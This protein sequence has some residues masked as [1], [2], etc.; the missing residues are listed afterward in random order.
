MSRGSGDGDN[1]DCAILDFENETKS[2]RA[3]EPVK[4]ENGEPLSD[5]PFPVSC[6]DLPEAVGPCERNSQS[7]LRESAG[8]QVA[9]RSL[10]FRAAT[11]SGKLMS[12]AP[13]PQPPH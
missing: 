9:S 4:I 8:E 6:G 1:Q 10:S 5:S 3:R 13:K 2:H 7:L 11:G 12:R